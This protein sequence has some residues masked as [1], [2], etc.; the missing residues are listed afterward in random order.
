MHELINLQYH[1]NEIEE[2]ALAGY[3]LIKILNNKSTL[4]NKYND[5]ILV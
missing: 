5:K 1:N 2:L 4:I 3:E